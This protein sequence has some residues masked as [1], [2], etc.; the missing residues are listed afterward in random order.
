MFATAVII[1]DIILL[2]YHVNLLV[3]LHLCN[4]FTVNHMQ[5]FIEAEC[6]YLISLQSS[7][8]IFSTVVI[9]VYVIFV[10]II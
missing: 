2:A 4:L 6:I 1:V 8:V 5:C 3:L 7:F 9:I 10:S